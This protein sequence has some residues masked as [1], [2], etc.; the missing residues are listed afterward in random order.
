MQYEQHCPRSLL[1]YSG[2][3]FGVAHRT[4]SQLRCGRVG[5][6]LVSETNIHVRN[7]AERR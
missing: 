5:L 4:K 3:Q 6:H 2:G 7:A 1:I